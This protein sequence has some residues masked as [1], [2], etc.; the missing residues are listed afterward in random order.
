MNL[1]GGALITPQLLSKLGLIFTKPGRK[2]FI[3]H[4]IIRTHLLLPVI[5]WCLWTVQLISR[6]KTPT[7][8]EEMYSRHVGSVKPLFYIL[9]LTQNKPLQY[10]IVLYY[11]QHMHIYDT[12]KLLEPRNPTLPHQIYFN[13]MEK[14]KQNIL[15]IIALDFRRQKQ[16]IKLKI[17]IFVRT[18]AFADTN[19]MSKTFEIQWW[20]IKIYSGY[21]L[22]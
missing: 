8:A 6:E 15:Q 11:L 14:N 2:F 19:I 16:T 17:Y 20:S 9:F 13:Y 12:L 4:L 22:R 1:P 18:W 10:C 21:V 3:L 7:E 5:S